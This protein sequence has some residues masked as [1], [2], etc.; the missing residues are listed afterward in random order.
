MRNYTIRMSKRW[1]VYFAVAGAVLI[2]FSCAAILY[3]FW[4]L[5]SLHEQIVIW[6]EMFRIP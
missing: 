2:C 3:A 4:P 1:R 6:S 5:S